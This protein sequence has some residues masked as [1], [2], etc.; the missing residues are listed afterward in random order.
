MVL[1]D[2][3]AALPRRLVSHGWGLDGGRSVRRSNT[4]SYLTGATE[5]AQCDKCAVR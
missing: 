1:H 5:Y 3:M 4:Y 2:G